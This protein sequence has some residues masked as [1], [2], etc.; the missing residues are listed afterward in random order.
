MSDPGF[1]L[2]K[3]RGGIIVAPVIHIQ[4]AEAWGFYVKNQKRLE[5]EL[6]EIASNEE[7]R[8]SVYITDED[9]VPYLY[10]YRD[11]KKIFQSECFTI[12]TTERNLRMIYA[13][14]LTPLR[15]VVGGKAENK[16]DDSPY[17]DAFYLAE[18]NDD[19]V[20]M[21]DADDEDNDLPPCSDIDAMSDAEFQDMVNEREDVIYAAVQDLIEV[22]TEDEASALEFCGEADDSIDTIID[23]IVEYLAIKCGFRIRRPMT[24]IDDDSGMYVRTE[25]PY[26]EYDF[27]ENE[28]RG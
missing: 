1:G 23:H 22:L 2:S 12:Y 4:P 6:V 15:V 28:L 20:P 26:E 27:S 14:Y 13:R 9:G 18:G 25:Y 19:S 21:P 24:I 17:N 11:D 16:E 10:V 3:N 8:T 7:T 5:E